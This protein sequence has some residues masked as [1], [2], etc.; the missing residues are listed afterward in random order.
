MS[1][2]PALYILSHQYQQLLDLDVPLDEKATTLAL[3]EESI[4]QKGKA[5]GAVLQSFDAQEL[6]LKAHLADV[7]AKVKA[8]QNHRDRLKAYLKENMENC[9]IQKIESPFFVISLQK[10]PESVVVDDEA[11]IPDDYCKVTRS[12]DKSLVKQALKDG[13]DIPGCHLEAG[14]HIRIR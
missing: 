5:I 6:A 11:R 10:S 9:G 12:V 14:T 7:Q 8:I 13:Y 4:E 3:L 2:L 1:E